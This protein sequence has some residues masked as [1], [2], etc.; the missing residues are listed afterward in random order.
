MGDERRQEYGVPVTAAYY[1]VNALRDDER[2]AA[3]ERAKQRIAGRKPTQDEFMMHRV[4][5]YPKQFVIA[6]V[7]L[8]GLMLVAA[9]LPSAMRIHSVA[10]EN[11]GKVISQAM[12]MYVAA[13]CIVLMSETGQIVFSLASATTDADKQ[14]QRIGFTLGAWV[15][16]AIALSGNAVASGDHATQDV[17]AFLETFAP[18]VLT[19]ITAE[20]LKSQMLNTIADRH[21]ARTQYELALEAWKRSVADAEHDA[22]WKRTLA[23]VV[24]DALRDANRRSKAMLR[25]LTSEDWYALVLRERNAG[26]WVDAVERRLESARQRIAVPQSDASAGS[27]STGATGEVAAQEVTQEGDV[28]VIACPHCAK[29]FEGRTQRHAQMRLTAHMKAHKN[30]QRKR[31]AQ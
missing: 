24:K 18:P 9:Y 11:Y 15:C 7:F 21:Q 1:R 2:D 31:V 5:K 4:S 14:K 25:D 16:T 17:F 3:Y 8:S 6:I 29:E 30:E 23:N 28:F 20:V 13:L 27:R 22:A 10:L 12:S 19:L 26:E